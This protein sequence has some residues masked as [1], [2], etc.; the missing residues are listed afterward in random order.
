MS[1]SAY[2]LADISQVTVDIGKTPNTAG[3]DAETV[4]AA[5]YFNFKRNAVKHSWLLAES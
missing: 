1:L 5:I 2:I 4:K 3:Y